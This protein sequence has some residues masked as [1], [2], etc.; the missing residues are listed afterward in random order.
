VGFLIDAIKNLESQLAQLGIEL[1]VQVGKSHEI[2]TQLIQDYHI[3]ALYH[4][5]SYG[6]G[7]Q[8]RDAAIQQR[9]AQHNIK[10]QNYSDYLL[11]EPQDVDQRKV[12]TPFYNLW[13]K[14]EK[15]PVQTLESLPQHIHTNSNKPIDRPTIQSQLSYLPNTQRPIDGHAQRLLQDMR[16]YDISRNELRHDGTTKLAPYV[17]FGLISIRQV[18][19]H[20]AMQDNPGAQV[21][22]SE[23][24]WREFWHHIMHYFPWTRAISFQ[25]KRRS[26]QRQNN[27]ARFEARKNGETG[28]PIIDAAM[29]QLKQENRMHNRARMIVA[30][31]LTKDLLIDRIR[32]E[33]HFAD[34]LL[35][36][37][38]N[39]N[40][41]NRQRS[42]SVGAD[43]KPLR[44]FSPILQAQRFDPDAT[45]IKKYLPE[46]SD[47]EPYR[48]HDPLTHKLPYITPI[49]D[50]RIMQ[51]Q[52]KQLYKD[53]VQIAH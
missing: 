32:G 30:S 16:N 51:Q 12:F 27:L 39:V 8:H 11:I 15:A 35:D 44:I 3:T 2:I 6:I 53:S 7:S 4:N 22:I 1:I 48:L 20:F 31:F 25:D 45:Y 42:A 10:Y 47:I 24:A 26:I 41:G 46:L 5:R 43:P 28:Y 29:R 13:K 38:S 36:Y 9:C 37:D 21:I 33:K 49:V 17:R 34:Y 40:I 19:R 52:A 23:L 50:H 14:V 18:Y